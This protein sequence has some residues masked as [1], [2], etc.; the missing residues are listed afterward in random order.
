MWNYETL[1]IGKILFLSKG[2]L[3]EFTQKKENILKLY[4]MNIKHFTFIKPTDEIIATINE[5]N[6]LQL[7][8]VSTGE[9]VRIYEFIILS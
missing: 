8:N 4:G 6:I 1:S 7:W 5:K 3:I 9:F 2:A